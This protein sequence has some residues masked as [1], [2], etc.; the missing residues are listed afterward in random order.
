MANTNPLPMFEAHGVQFEGFTDTQAY[1]VCPFTGKSKKFYVN[2]QTGLWDSKVA[3]KSGDA[4]HFLTEMTKVYASQITPKLMRALA[5]DRKLPVDAFQGWDIGWTGREYTIPAIGSDGVVTDIRFYTPGRRMRSTVGAKTNMMGAYR[6]LADKSGMVFVCEGEWDTIAWAWALRVAERAGAV[7]GVPGASTFKPEW[8][9]LM[10]NR[11]VFAM[12]DHDTAGREGLQKCAERCANT[13][14]SVSGLTWPEGT[15]DGWDVRDEIAGNAGNVLRVRATVKSLLGRFTPVVLHKGM[16]NKAEPPPAKKADPAG[17]VNTHA[18]DPLLRKSKWKHGPSIGDVE[19]V[20]RK[21]LFLENTDALRV[22]LACIVSQNIDGSPIWVFLVAPPGGSKTEHLNSLSW[23]DNIFMTSSL[24]PHSLIS[25]ANFKSNED[26]SL[27]PQLDGK[28]LVIKDFTAIIGMRDADKEEIFAILRDAYDGHCG[29]VFGNGIQRK[30]QS[31]FTILGA[32]TPKIY[33]LGSNHAS[34]GERFLKFTLGDNLN[35]VA[36]KDIIRRAI[37]NINRET[38][39]RDEMAD[40]VNA[41]LTKTVNAKV[42]PTIDDN[43]MELIVNLSQFGA[44]MRGTVSRD[45]YRND[46]M[47]S[48]PSAEVG[49]RL[50]VQMAKLGQ[51]LAIVAGRLSV[52]MEDYRLIKKTMLDTVPQRLEDMVRLMLRVCPTEQNWVSIRELEALTRYPSATVNRLLQDLVVLD[53][54][55]RETGTGRPRYTLSAYIRG[56][57][58]AAQLYTTP[59]ELKRKATIPMR[60]RRR[61]INGVAFK[62]PARPLQAAKNA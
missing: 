21:W 38:T 30:Y 3:G 12:Y 55:R 1:G 23:V 57:I 51:S 24:T 44:R 52:S 43:V 56:L 14:M 31:R 20:F 16:K 4:F 53:V 37:T 27:I 13:A 48:K 10:R 61:P 29:K 32:V 54:V 34:L 17:E 35:H 28:V 9:A 62:A 39:M 11:R 18:A 58:T 25:G 5:D 45:P 19:T 46:V 47:T 50:G 42:I 6:L 60:A 7:V 33:D 41:F 26:P 8:A 49:S 22:M 40:V 2:R 59:E 15:A 36:E